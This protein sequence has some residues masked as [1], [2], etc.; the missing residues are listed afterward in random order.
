M[1]L[2]DDLAYMTA[3]ELA[4]RIRSRQLSPVE[5]VDAFIGRIEERNPSLNA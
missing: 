5:V 3:T 2:S 4:W 1:K